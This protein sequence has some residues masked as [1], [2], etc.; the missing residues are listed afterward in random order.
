[1]FQVAVEAAT[2]SVAFILMI[3]VFVLGMITPNTIKLMQI[4]ALKYVFA[5][6]T[7]QILCKPVQCILYHTKSMVCHHYR[8]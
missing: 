4:M 6:F 7:L 5:I 2:F 1:M 8:L 3:L